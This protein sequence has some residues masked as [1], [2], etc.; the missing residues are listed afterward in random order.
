MRKE[1]FLSVRF[2]GLFEGAARGW[3]AIVA[4]VVILAMVLLR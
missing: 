3:I 4:L 1:A 2:G